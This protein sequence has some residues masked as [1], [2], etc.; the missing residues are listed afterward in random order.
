MKPQRKRAHN[1]QTLYTREGLR[2]FRAEQLIEQRRVREHA[3]LRAAM[4]VFAGIGTRTARPAGHY[5]QHIG[6]VLF[7]ELADPEEW[8]VGDA[9]EEDD[10]T[11]TTVH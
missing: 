5:A 1:R 11:P 2:R 7:S 6:R 4:A 8:G 9:F 3:H 10:D